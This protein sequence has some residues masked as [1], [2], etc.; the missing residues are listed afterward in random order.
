MRVRRTYYAHAVL[1]VLL[2]VADIPLHAQEFVALF[3]GRDL[4]GWN[5]E[6]KKAEVRDGVIHVGS[7]NG[8]LR[9]ERVLTDFI[10]KLDV[11]VTGKKTSAGLFIRSWPTFT[12][13]RVP[14]SGY[15][16]QLIVG[17][18]SQAADGWKRLEIECIGHTVRVRMNGA[19]V[20]T[21]EDIQ[22]GEGHLALWSKDGTAQFKE[23]QITA[24]SPLRGDT[25]GA[26]TVGNGVSAPRQIRR[27]NPRY[28]AAAMEERI[29][30][31][32]V[33]SGIV[34]PDGTVSDIRVRRSL[35][36]RF[37]LDYQAISAVKE[38]RFEPGTRDGKPVPVRIV[39][40]L[41][42]NLR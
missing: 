30:G 41:E 2:C 25:T 21:A 31:I 13:S 8:W 20:F 39:M 35:D 32:V 9:T 10:L 16:L 19:V 37:G 26:F 17:Q 33:L 29:T 6:H 22:V 42:F 1:F 11:R 23:L 38:W 12:R 4:S 40:E 34:M 3:N 7:G 36:Q 15:Q 27:G 14:T 28:T 18:E 24:L 5:A